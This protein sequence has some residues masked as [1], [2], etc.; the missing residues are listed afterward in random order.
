MILDAHNAHLTAV[1][2]PETPADDCAGETAAPGDSKWTG[3]CEAFIDADT[4]TVIRGGQLL[5]VSDTWITLPQ[6]FPVMPVVGDTLQM[7]RI[8]AIPSSER[9]LNQ[10]YRVTMVDR[11]LIAVGKLR[12]RSKLVA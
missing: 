3:D 4:T 9:L 12:L 11:G 5:V 10:T 7:K 6:N 2:G 8:D 1:N